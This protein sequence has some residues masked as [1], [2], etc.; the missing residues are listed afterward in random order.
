MA[1]TEKTLAEQ[2]AAAICNGWEFVVRTSICGAD[3]ELLSEY[4]LI[5][6]I[7]SVIEARR[8]GEADD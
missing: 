6:I 7:E 3:G 8:K 4:G 5:D 1:E 2:I